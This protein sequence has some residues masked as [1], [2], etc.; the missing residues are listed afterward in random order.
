VLSLYG[1]RVNLF[2]LGRM[3]A[4]FLIDRQGIVR[5]AHYGRGM[6]DIPENSEILKR[7]DALG[8]RV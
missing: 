1:Q 8:E 3:P 2:K 5:Y 4:Q 6:G 7:V